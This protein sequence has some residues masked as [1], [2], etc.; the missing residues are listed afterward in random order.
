MVDFLSL[1]SYGFLGGVFNDFSNT[2]LD[3]FTDLM[4]NHGDWVPYRAPMTSELVPCSTVTRGGG[5]R[6]CRGRGGGAPDLA[7]LAVA[8]RGD[9]A[10]GAAAEGAIAEGAASGAAAGIFEAEG[11]GMSSTWTAAWAMAASVGNL[12]AEGARGSTPVRISGAG[13]PEKLNKD[14]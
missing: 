4:R 14:S 9:A 11:S 7:A 12:D 1:G 13:A 6:A 3:E 10:A 8:S 5:P 2:V